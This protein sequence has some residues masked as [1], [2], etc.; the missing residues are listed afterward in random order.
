VK[1]ELHEDASYEKPWHSLWGAIYGNLMCCLAIFFLL[2]FISSRDTKGFFPQALGNV[3]AQFGQQVAT[4]PS[5]A[6][7]SLSAFGVEEIARLDVKENRMKIIFGDPVLFDSGRA[8]LKPGALP[9]LNRLAAQLKQL[10]TPIQIEGHTDD[11]PLPAKSPFHSN[12]E[13]SAARAFSVLRYLQQQGVPPE[14]LSGIGYGEFKPLRP[15]TSMENRGINR[16]IE[17][18]LVRLED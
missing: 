16:R 1:L 8:T 13:L 6:N 7:T 14:R 5:L 17:I 9:H 12:W 15:N 3:S 11:Q 4:K 10:T 18:T 2:L